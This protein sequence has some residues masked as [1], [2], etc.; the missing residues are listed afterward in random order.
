MHVLSAARCLTLLYLCRTCFIGYSLNRWVVY[1]YAEQRLWSNLRPFATLLCGTVGVLT[2]VVFAV[3]RIGDAQLWCW[4]ESPVMR[5][6]L[7]Y[8][9]VALAWG[10]NA[11]VLAQVRT[12]L[13]RRFRGESLVDVSQQRAL[14]ERKAREYVGLFVFIWAFGLLNRTLNLAGLVLF[15]PNVLHCLFVPLQGAHRSSCRLRGPAYVF[16]AVRC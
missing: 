16:C 4:I 2:G 5:F 15:V 7:F 1:G 3:S 9:W 8:G 14:V 13:L 11:Y 12:A 6:P 10:Y